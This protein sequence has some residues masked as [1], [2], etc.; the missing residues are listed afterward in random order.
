MFE[1]IDI[2]ASTQWKINKKVLGIVE[3]IFESGGGICE[4]PDKHF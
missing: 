4:I 3:E 1:K 2:I